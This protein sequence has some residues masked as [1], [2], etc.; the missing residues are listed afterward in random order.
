MIGFV[1]QDDQL[2]AVTQPELCEYPAQ[3]RL[4]RQRAENQLRAVDTAVNG[5]AWPLTPLLPTADDTALAAFRKIRGG[6][7]RAAP[8][9]SYFGSIIV[10]C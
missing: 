5:A 7:P 4:D 6:C 10:G 1:G 8:S 3:M 9:I 2:R